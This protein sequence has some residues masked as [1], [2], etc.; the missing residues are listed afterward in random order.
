MVIWFQVMAFLFLVSISVVNSQSDSV[1]LADEHGCKAIELQGKVLEMKG[2]GVL[3]LHLGVNSIL[4]QMIKNGYDDKE[5]E[6]GQK[7]LSKIE[8]RWGQSVDFLIKRVRDIKDH[9]E[10]LNFYLKNPSRYNRHTRS[11][12]GFA[13]ALGLLDL[14]V[15][16]ASYFYTDYRLRQLKQKLSD[17]EGK[18]DQIMMDERSFT[19]NQQYLF[20]EDEI[21]GIHRNLIVEQVNKLEETHSCDVL[22]MKLDEQI[23]KMEIYF[24]RLVEAAMM[25]SLTHYVLDIVTL[26][27]MTRAKNFDYT[28]YRVAP[29]YLYS[30]SKLSIHSVTDKSITFVVT[31]PI[32]SQDPVFQEVALIE[33]SDNMLVSR[34]DLSKNFRFLIPTDVPLANAKNAIDDIRSSDACIRKHD[35]VACFKNVIPP[36]NT[37]KCLDSVLNGRKTGSCFDK[38][39]PSKFSVSYGKVGA[40]I[41]SR[42][43]GQI[44][45]LDNGKV[46]LNLNGNKCTYIEKRQNLGI[47]MGSETLNLYPKS[48]VIDI[49]TAR[50]RPLKFSSRTP[51][52]FT[53]PFIPNPKV[54]KNVTTFR[55]GVSP[56]SYL[57]NPFV[58]TCVIVSFIGI[59]VMCVICYLC[60]SKCCNRNGGVNVYNGVDGGML[61]R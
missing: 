55:S 26:E 47:K 20:K 40:L 13:V 34:N 15:T 37:L 51:K 41:Q 11:N 28:L 56:L 4:P 14:V 29:I 21:L 58:A 35:L 31:Y 1:L 7:C 32:I 59:T 9:Q 23:T 24:D 60:V 18:L 53:L 25:N 2:D 6:N 48:P 43:T 45:N 30:L 46:L 8:S 57:K 33:T 42:E 17:M 10:F 36:T 19:Q 16:G 54:F 52:N 39:D 49:K 3:Y 5:D 38:G 27:H 61:N 12:N 44:V 50:A 22:T